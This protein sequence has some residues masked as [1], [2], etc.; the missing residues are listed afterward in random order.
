MDRLVTVGNVWMGLT[1]GCARCHDHKF[2]PITQQEF[3]QLFAFFNQVPE[4]GMRGFTP[5]ATIESPLASDQ[6]AELDRD[7]ASVRNQLDQPIDV[8]EQ[9]AAWVENLHATAN[10]QVLTP[11]ELTSSG[12]S[13]LTILDDHSILVGQA[14]PRKDVYDIVATSEETGLTAVRL[15]C[16][17]HESLPGGGPGR[18]SNSNFVL[19]E[20]ELT[21]VSVANPESSVTVKFREAK[22]DY[23][24]SGYEVAKAIDGTVAGNN[25]WAVD[26]PTRKGTGYRVA[27]RRPAIRLRRRHEAAISIAT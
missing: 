20:F 4:R 1:L 5:S 10:W 3:Y 21:A 17:T 2:D 23:S 13:K 15:E 26:G 19:S 24:Q 27:D 7:I 8:E 16:L 18:H 12:G 25:G 9:L 14:N 6:A 22:A 11:T